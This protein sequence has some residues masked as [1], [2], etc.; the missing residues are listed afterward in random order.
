MEPIKETPKETFEVIEE[1]ANKT[2]VL[3]TREEAKAQGLTESEI[4]SAEKRGM[5]SKP[6]DAAAA[7]EKADADAKAAEAA[8]AAAAEKGDEKAEVKPSTLPDFTFKTPEQEKAFLDAFGSGTPQRAMYFRMKNERQS[9]QA[10]E[11]ERD[12]ER[13]KREALEARIATLEKGAPTLDDN[14]EIVDP[15]DR[16]LTLKQLREI[17]K[18]EAEANQKKNDENQQRAERLADAQRTQEDYTKFIYPDFDDTVEKAKEIMQ[19]LETLLPEK[20]QQT[21]AVKLIRELQIAAAHADQIDLDDQHAALIAYELGKMHPDFGKTNGYASDKDGKSNDPKKANGGYTP[22]QLKRLEE[23]TQR[24]ASSASV[25]GGG[26]K[27]VVS[28]D[29]VDASTLNK[30]NY[31]ERQ[32]FKQKNPDQYARLLRG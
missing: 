12:K 21:K 14:G 3:P 13:T 23:N 24:R 28:A 5:L 16:P 18:A 22:E 32:R 2:A 27:R 6:E 17:Q 8:K 7:K 26:G 19:K 30:M 29:D 20:W 15:D 25:Q 31:A 4:E 1:T 11:A 9:R 10:A